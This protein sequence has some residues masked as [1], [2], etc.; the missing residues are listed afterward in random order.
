MQYLRNRLLLPFILYS[1]I[2]CQTTD[3]KKLIEPDYQLESQSEYRYSYNLNGL[4][5]STFSDHFVYLNGRL[6]YINHTFTISKYNSSNNLI[7]EQDY[8]REE[9]GVKLV[10]EKQLKYNDKLQLIEEIDISNGQMFMKR[11][12][13]YN[14]FDS[15]AKMTTLIKRMAGT[16]EEAAK[17]DRKNVKY[18]TSVVQYVYNDKKQR[19]IPEPGIDKT[20]ETIILN[21]SI[22]IQIIRYPEDGFIDST[23]YKRD[24]KIRST[25]IH[26]LEGTKSKNVTY[27]NTQGDIIKSISLKRIN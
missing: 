22:S 23:W 7:L 13:E 8:E 3:S 26:H 18:D 6:A 20:A 2:S 4:I 12:L 5:D 21:D 14:A 1:F 10:G 11:I 17:A 16:L 19:I 27:Y 24:T 15:L 25:S 9:E